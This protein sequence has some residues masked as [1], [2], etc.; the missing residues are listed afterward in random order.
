MIVAASVALGASFLIHPNLAVIVV[1][2]S[3]ALYAL[4]ITGIW[5]K[6]QIANKNQEH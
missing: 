3:T 2:I 1:P 6:R 5:H 4:E